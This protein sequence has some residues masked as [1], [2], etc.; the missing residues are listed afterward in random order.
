MLTALESLTSLVTIEV[1]LST[2]T[3]KDL[4]AVK[5][6]NVYYVYILLL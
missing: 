5:Q 3:K 1:I 4:N 2:V 6:A